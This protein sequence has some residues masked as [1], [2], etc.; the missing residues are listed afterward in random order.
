MPADEQK[1][2]HF[3]FTE[4]RIQYRYKNGVWTHLNGKRIADD[5]PRKPQSG[6]AF[7]QLP[8]DADG[9]SYVPK[10]VTLENNDNAN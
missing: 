2:E 7:V 10:P 8:K 1:S 4:D 3:E 5:P 9:R 6:P